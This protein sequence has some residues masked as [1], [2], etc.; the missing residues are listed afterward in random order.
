MDVK[1]LESIRKNIIKNKEVSRNDL[2]LL[3][4]DDLIYLV[5]RLREDY[6][7]LQDNY[8]SMKE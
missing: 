5:L 1:L 4:K 6:Q 2:E 7:L 3:E 8:F